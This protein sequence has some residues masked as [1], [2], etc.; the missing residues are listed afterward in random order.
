MMCRFSSA[1][2]FFVMAV[3]T[4]MTMTTMNGV[5]AFVVPISSITSSAT[6]TT[7]TT[8]Y[9][10]N[11]VTALSMMDLSVASSLSETVGNVVMMSTPSTSL[12][13]AETEA[14]VKP[15]STCLGPFL[16]FMVRLN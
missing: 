2:L 12:L 5:S 3:T 6:T 15:V 7:T 8:T 4:T 11:Y 13:L 14:W 16:N 10:T 9:T 1:I